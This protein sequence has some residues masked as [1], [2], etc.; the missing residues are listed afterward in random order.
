MH[1]VRPEETSTLRL[2][3]VVGDTAGHTHPALAVAEA[4]RRHAP[5]TRVIFLGTADS[6]AASIVTRAGHPFFPVP[7]SPIRGATL[8]GLARA[9]T[10]TTQAIVIARRILADHHTQLVM[11]F[12]GFA[13]GGVLLAARSLRVPTAILEANVDV[14]LA[15]RWL[16]PWV[17][18]V[19]QGLGPPQS[20][21]G[22]PIRASMSA[23]TAIHR[24][25]P[26]V[27]LRVLVASG[28]RGSDF[29]DEQ[30]PPVLDQ[31]GALGIRVHVRQQSDTPEPLRERYAHLG[32]A[33]NIDG[34]VDD[35]ADAHAWA[36]VAIARGGASTIA[37]LAAAGVPALLVPLADAS[38]NHQAANAALWQ[39]AGAG[40]SVT[41]RDWHRDLAVSWLQTMAT[42][43]ASWQIQSRA[44]HT[45]ARVGAADDIAAACVQL[46]Q[47][48]Q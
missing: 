20:S 23:D 43:P 4:I 32:I 24:S 29:L 5:A 48:S 39:R 12:G 11:G 10:H 44:A 37:E 2:A 30:L 22:V 21:T 9:A 27:P 41:E 25:S 13:S 17:T 47:R 38:A 36:D 35:F 26:H 33:A 3:L 8:A 7:G 40:L 31:L 15:N 42:D 28:S 18:R 16:R 6:V 46:I 45:L 19:F 34:F 1:W 14:G